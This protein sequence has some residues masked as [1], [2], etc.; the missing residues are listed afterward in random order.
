MFNRF[1]VTVTVLFL[2]LGVGVIF[3]QGD[4]KTDSETVVQMLKKYAAAVRS[5][6]I[7]EM[8]KYVVTSDDFSMFEGGHINWGWVDYRDHHIAP[9]FKT[10]LEF[11]YNYEDIKAQV[12]G[13]MAY[14][15]LK[16]DMT[17][18][19]KEREISGKGLATVVLIKQDGKWKIQHMHTSRI[20]KRDH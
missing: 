19:M 17:I 1:S 15:T 6:D 20:P 8:E 3:A 7:D 14:A 18:K 10:F 12:L 9:E 11:K 5:M 13:D 16:Y 2:I 4:Q